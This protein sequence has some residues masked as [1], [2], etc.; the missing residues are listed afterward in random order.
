MR[1]IKG[2]GRKDGNVTSHDFSYVCSC[3]FFGSFLW[4]KCEKLNK[5]TDAKL[6]IPKPTKIKE[7]YFTFYTKSENSDSSL[8][9]S[10]EVKTTSLQQRN[11]FNWEHL[12]HKTKWSRRFLWIQRNKKPSL[13]KVKF[14]DQQDGESPRIQSYDLNSI[15]EQRDKYF[16]EIIL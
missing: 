1:A 8:K 14:R 15:L 11:R 9:N 4:T 13:S 10:E 12:T 6:I 3:G 16:S 7:S 2:E 5:P